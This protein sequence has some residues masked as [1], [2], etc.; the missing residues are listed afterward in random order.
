MSKPT[1]HVPDIT[2]TRDDVLDLPL[3][4]ADLMPDEGHVWKLDH[5]GQ[6]LRWVDAWGS[7]P[8]MWR[9]LQDG[10]IAAAERA[11][12]WRSMLACDAAFDDI[13][14]DDVAVI[15]APVVTGVTAVQVQD[16]IRRLL[17]TRPAAA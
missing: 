13:E 15:S 5:V 1:P 11:V 10:E 14:H 6:R 8:Y 17:K 12:L 16:A 2:V 7:E 3:T 9:A 4:A